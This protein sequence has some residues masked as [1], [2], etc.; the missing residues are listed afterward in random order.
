MTIQE[1]LK[2]YEY[3]ISEE[4]TVKIPKDGYPPFPYFKH[5]PISARENY[6]RFLRGEKPVYMPYDTDELAVCP[7]IFPDCRARAFVVDNVGLEPENYGGKDMFGIEWVYIPQ[8]GG[9]MVRPGSPAVPDIEEWEKYITFPDIDEWDWEGSAKANAD[10]FVKEYA[11]NV[12]IF[13]GLF[14]RLISFMDFE[15]AAVALIDE[16]QKEGV[17]RL[18][19]RLC[20]LY[21]DMIVRIKKY[22]NP[23]VIYFHDDWGGQRSPFFSLE[24]CREMLVPYLKRVVDATHNNGMLFNFHSCGCIGEALV[25]AMIDAGVNMWDG[26][27]MNDYK[28]IYDKYGTDFNI[29]VQID[30]PKADATLEEVAAFCEKYLDDFTCNGIGI[31]AVWDSDFHPDFRKV[32]Y[33]LSRERFAQ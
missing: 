3:E 2:K 6:L 12:W 28:A 14:E 8:V 1:L 31:P 7:Y 27:E 24:V 19:D 26:Q 10:L 30:P 20:T 4:G 25:P 16:E 15:N 32:M 17:H 23:D 9:S 11:T 22:Y 33:V 18:F 21:E 5:A 13:N 29:G